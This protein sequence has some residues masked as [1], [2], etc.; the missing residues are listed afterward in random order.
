M[1]KV[2]SRPRR[3]LCVPIASITR[4][5]SKRSWRQGNQGFNSCGEIRNA[6]KL[7]GFFFVTYFYFLVG[8]GGWRFVECIGGILDGSS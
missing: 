6:T 1:S 7:G 5:A 4:Y 2:P 3:V 8:V